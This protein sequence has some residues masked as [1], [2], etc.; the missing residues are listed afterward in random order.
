MEAHHYRQMSKEQWRDEKAKLRL[1]CRRYCYIKDKLESIEDNLKPGSPNYDG[2]PKASNVES[3][4][5]K[6]AIQLSILQDDIDMIHLAAEQADFSMAQIIVDYVSGKRM[7]YNALK[8]EGKISVGRAVFFQRIDKFY[9][10][11]HQLRCE[12]T[13]CSILRQRI[14]Q[15][16]A[17]KDWAHRKK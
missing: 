14:R 15:G 13:N 7:S 11:L 2:M 9:R 17:R 8:S 4:V 12:S 1:L 3:T 10:C 6:K 5:E 16:K